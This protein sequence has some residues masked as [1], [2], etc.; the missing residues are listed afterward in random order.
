MER[1]REKGREKKKC[2]RE[3]ARKKKNIKES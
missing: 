1:K 3:R 2:E